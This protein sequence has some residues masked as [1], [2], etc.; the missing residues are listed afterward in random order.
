LIAAVVVQAAVASP[1]SA[2]TVELISAHSPVTDHPSPS[3]STVPY[4]QLADLKGKIPDRDLLSM[5]D[6]D[7]D[8]V[9][10][11]AVWAQIQADVQTEIDG[12]LGRRYATP[13]TDP[14]PAAVKLA[15]QLF[16]I[17]AV[18]KRRGLLNDK[19]QETVAAKNIRTTLAAIADGEE[20]LSPGKERA[21][22]SGSA[23]TSPS[24]THSDRPAI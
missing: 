12:T 5:L 19:S 4:V 16:A 3:S 7:Q 1:A 14:L 23:I 20:P 8:G 22:P 17:E 21:R 24:R 11:A 6:D 10:D 2:Q 18:Y 15:A 13:F 9:I